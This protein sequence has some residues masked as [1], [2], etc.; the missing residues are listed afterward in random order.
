MTDNKEVSGWNGIGSSE[1]RFKKVAGLSPS[2]FKKNK[3]E[4]PFRMYKT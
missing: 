4:S 2:H 1:H 3:G